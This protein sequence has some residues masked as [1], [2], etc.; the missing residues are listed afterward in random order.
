MQSGRLSTNL[1]LKRTNCFEIAQNAVLHSQTHVR[2]ET[3]A[4]MHSDEDNALRVSYCQCQ[5]ISWQKTSNLRL[6]AIPNWTWSG[7]FCVDM[8]VCFG[9][10][11]NF[12][13]TFKLMFSSFNFY[14]FRFTKITSCLSCRYFF[15]EFLQEFIYI[16]RII[17]V[18]HSG[19]QR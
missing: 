12:D 4:H 18:Q 8:L 14:H 19:S 3:S 13:K 17:A 11:G 10:F 6:H 16:C 1:K 5:W 2:S 15:C 7:S 9:L